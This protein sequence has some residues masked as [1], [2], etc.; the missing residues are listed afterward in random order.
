VNLMRKWYHSELVRLNQTREELEGAMKIIDA[1]KAST[2]R[3]HYDG[4]DPADDAMLSRLLVERQL[5]TTADWPTTAEVDNAIAEAGGLGQMVGS[6]L[7]SVATDDSDAAGPPGEDDDDEEDME[8]FPGGELF[9][10]SPPLPALAPA[11]SESASS[12][13]A[14]ILD[15]QEPMP[16][17]PARSAPAD[18]AEDMPPKKHRRTLTNTEQDTLDEYANPTAGMRMR[19]VVSAEASEWMMSKLKEWQEEHGKH[20]QERPDDTYWY[21]FKRV[22]AIKLGLLNKY[23]SDDVVRSHIMNKMK[24]S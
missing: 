1:H 11:A 4:R 15:V 9:G 14:P 20:A 6:L 2:A 8:Y 19:A 3:A 16:P 10:L 12:G 13:P 18:S 23:H 21:K 17:H 5:K 24:P 7:K 22:D